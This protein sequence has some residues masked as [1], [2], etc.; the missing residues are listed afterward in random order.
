MVLSG[1]GGYPGD[2]AWFLH[3]I[4]HT[5]HRELAGHPQLAR[6]QVDV[7]ARQ[8]HAQID[9]GELLYIA[10]QLDYLARV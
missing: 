5:V 4:V 9:A 10:H 2:E 8:R 7:W 1:A 6:A 3:A